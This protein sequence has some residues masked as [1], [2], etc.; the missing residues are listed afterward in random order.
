MLKANA[1]IG[2]RTADLFPKVTLLGSLGYT[3]PDMSQLFNSTSQTL[4]LAP[5]PKWSPFDL[6]RTKAKIAQAN[7]AY[8][9]LAANYRKTVLQALQDTDTSLSRYGRQRDSVTSQLR[10]QA[11]ADRSAQLQMLR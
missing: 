3:A 7:S 2:Q 5:I 8:D 11:S 1:L 6:G 10:V 4:T 9:E